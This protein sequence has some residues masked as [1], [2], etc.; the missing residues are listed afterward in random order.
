M[1]EDREK[2]RIIGTATKRKASIAYA[3]SVL[4]HVREAV[5]EA[6]R[7]DRGE[8]LR[9]IADWLNTRNPP[10]LTQKGRRF[11]AQTVSRLLY[12][13][14]EHIREAAEFEFKVAAG[15]LRY[16]ARALKQKPDAGEIARLEAERDRIIAEGVELGRQMRAED[17]E[18]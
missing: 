9:A 5:L 3:K 4:P 12:Q 8:S 6:R 11:R 14:E 17:V 16:K 10:V 18:P 15:I 1:D 7:S 13:T 2:G